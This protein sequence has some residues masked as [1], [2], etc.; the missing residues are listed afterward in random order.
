MCRTL[1]LAL[2]RLHAHATSVASAPRSTTRPPAA[3]D[4]DTPALANALFGLLFAEP[5]L[6]ELDAPL[7]PFE[8]VPA[9]PFVHLE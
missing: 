2:S 7:M 3:A 4:V 5:L 8:P 6:F 9:D 1:K